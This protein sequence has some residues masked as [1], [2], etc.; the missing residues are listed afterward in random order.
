MFKTSLQIGRLRGVPIRLH[1]TLALVI[2]YLGFEFARG[3]RSVAAQ[4]EIP[5]AASSGVLLLWGF[6]LSVA[7]FAS[8]LVHEMSHVIVAQMA[9]GHVRSVTLMLLGGVAEIERMPPGGPEARMAIIGPLASIWLGLVS[10]L[11]FTW[12]EGAAPLVRLF[13]YYLAVTNLIIGAFNLLPAFP[14]D[15]GRV[16]R[17]LLRNRFGQ[18][19]A[20]AIAAGV[21]KVIAIA[22]LVAGLL[23]KD[24][25]LSLIALFLFVAGDA[26]ARDTIVREA[27]RGMRVGDLALRKVPVLSWFDTVDEARMAL[28]RSGAP[29]IAVVGPDGSPTALTL[30]ELSRACS[31]GSAGPATPLHRLAMRSCETVGED[32]DIER[33]LDVMNRTAREVL[34]VRGDDGPAGILRR[35]D[36]VRAV[37]LSTLFRR[38]SP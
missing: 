5:L 4:T 21:S 11:A 6:L 8:I 19:K 12:T 25:V 32:D 28:A 36:I 22:M 37:Q 15:G 35:D 23:L 10:F 20:T 31:S 27:L 9:G 14:L 33:A 1:F 24:L 3:V 26:E 30:L 2:P 7:I 18:A 13:L 16:L 29:A 17:A 34:L 38:P